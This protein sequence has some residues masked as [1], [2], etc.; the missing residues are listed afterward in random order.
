LVPESAFRRR[1]EEAGFV[2]DEVR[3]LT[4]QV[5]STWPRAVARLARRIPTDPGVR[6]VLFSSEYENQGFLLSI[7][8]MT[9]GYRLGAV[10]FC[11]VV[12]HKP[13]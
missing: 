2:V 13:E 10:R 5:R 6:K 1:L 9:V 7:L 3:D 4:K 11:L 8:R 12:A